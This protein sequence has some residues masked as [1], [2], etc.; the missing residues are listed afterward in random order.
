MSDGIPGTASRGT[1]GTVRTVAALRGVVE[2]WRRQGQTVALV[3]TMGFLHDGHFALI[4]AGA[5]ACDRVVVSI[6]VNPTQ[7]GANE[8]FTGYP[9]NTEADLAELDARGVDLAFLPEVEEIYPDGFQTTVS[10]SGVTQGLCG[11]VRPGHFDGVATVVAKLFLQCLPDVATFGEKDYQ[12]LT[13]VRRMVRDLDIPVRILAVE[14]VREADGMAL[15]SRN[16]YLTESERRVAVALNRVLFETADK[17]AAGA[18]AA[19]TVA[20]AHDRL[21]GAGF[22]AVQ[23][24]ELRDAQDLHP[25]DSV[26]RPARLLAAVVLGRT[27]LI[28]NVA[29]APPA[30]A[31][32]AEPS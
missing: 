24:L 9:R 17:L 5:A 21:S 10:V 19:E 26:A 20:A 6:F 18:P 4:D 25:V 30:T 27:R 7:F 15:S 2:Q 12:Q 11:A 31:Q 14:T 29:V 22:D 23:Y 32:V 13:M 3:P 28:D 1:L 8:D 16:V